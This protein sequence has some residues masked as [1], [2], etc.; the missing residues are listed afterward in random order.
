LNKLA[1]LV[2]V[3]MAAAA[4][5]QTTYTYNGSPIP[6]PDSPDGNCGA[7]AFAE[8]FVPDNF[9]IGSVQVSFYIPH[10]FQG[11]LKISLRHQATGREIVLMDQPG[12]P[13]SL[14]GYGASNYGSGGSL[15]TMSDSAGSRYDLPQ[16]AVPGI[17]SVTGAWKPEGALATFAGESANGDW[18]LIAR[19]CAG[20]DTGM[21][22]NFTLTISGAQPCYANCDGSQQSPVLNV[23]DLTCF[24]SRYSA[25]CS[26][27]QSCYANCD[28]STQQ[29]FL[30]MMD[31]TCFL[32][33]FSA[34]CTAP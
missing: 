2:A 29:P 18:R 19:D 4:Q 3:G 21:I 28:G 30:N 31:F 27:P 6:I 33:K 9:T 34:G 22:V 17:P 23:A 13:Q 32:Q 24:L 5:A 7:E 26:S 10:P 25:G 15:M 16:I 1:L 11:D 14:I 12:N 8:I 20:M